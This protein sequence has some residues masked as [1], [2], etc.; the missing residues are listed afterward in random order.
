MNYILIATFLVWWSCILN[1]F[2]MNGRKK[3]CFKAIVSYEWLPS[4]GN[5][6]Q[7]LVA[8]ETNY[9]HLC[10]SSFI[11]KIQ[12][13]NMQSTGSWRGKHCG[14]KVT[15]YLQ[16]CLISKQCSAFS[17]NCRYL[18]PYIKL[19][20]TNYTKIFEIKWIVEFFTISKHNLPNHLFKATSQSEFCLS[21]IE[22]DP[23]SMIIIII[24]IIIITTTIFIYT[25]QIQLNFPNVPY[26]SQIKCWFLQRGKPEY[27]EKNLLEQSREPIN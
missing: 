6:K 20:L 8:R 27:L 23:R 2:P 26:N 21:L 5:I 15:V 13:Q 1:F 12:K 7:T 9:W 14:F 25:A 19:K 22:A 3:A 10:I 4:R 11:L 18:N 24:I 16:G 17:L